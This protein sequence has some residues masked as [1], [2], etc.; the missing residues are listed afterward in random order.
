MAVMIM[1]IMVMVPFMVFMVFMAMTMVTSACL[2]Q[3]R[4]SQV[5]S[6][7]CDQCQTGQ[8]SCC[9]VHVASPWYLSHQADS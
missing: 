9:C 7:K 2:G 5:D 4:Y 1:T 8:T 6:Q 3:G